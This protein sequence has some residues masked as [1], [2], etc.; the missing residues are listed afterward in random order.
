V[1]FNP[2]GLIVTA[3]G[4]LALWVAL[5]THTI[6]MFDLAFRITLWTVVSILSAVVVVGTIKGRTVNGQLGAFRELCRWFRHE[7]RIS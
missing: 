7:R 2:K 4:V 6:P 5:Q 1:K 3:V